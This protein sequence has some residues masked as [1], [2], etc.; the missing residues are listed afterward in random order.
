MKLIGALLFALAG[1][2]AGEEKEKMKFGDKTIER[3]RLS[4]ILSTTADGFS[5]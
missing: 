4:G 5:M 2:V 3:V 1:L